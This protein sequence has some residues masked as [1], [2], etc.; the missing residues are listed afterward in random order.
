[1]LSALEGSTPNDLCSTVERR[2]AG[3][4]EAALAWLADHPQ[5]ELLHLP[6]YSG[7]KENPVEKIWWQLKARVAANRLHGS[8]ECLIAAIHEFCDSLTPGAALQLAA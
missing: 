5:V 4:V 3:G 7:H 2:G 6:T 8:M 1:M